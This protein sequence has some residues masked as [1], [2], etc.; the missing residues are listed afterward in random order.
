[1]ATVTNALGDAMHAGVSN[2]SSLQSSRQVDPQIA[3]T[4]AGTNLNNA[5]SAKAAAD[6]TS[7]LSAANLNNAN[8]SKVRSGSIASD[9]VGSDLAHKGSQW[10]NNAVDNVSKKVT[11]IIDNVTNSS[12]LKAAQPSVPKFRLPQ[13]IDNS[14]KPSSQIFPSY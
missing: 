12:A 6:A 11:N 8:A 7:A 13:I 9:V 2:Y 5:L 4:N 3:N 14:S 10:L 1:M